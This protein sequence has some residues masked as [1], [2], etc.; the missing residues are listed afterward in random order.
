M[1]SKKT[2]KSFDSSGIRYR[3]SRRSRLRDEPSFAVQFDECRDTTTL[4]FHAASEERGICIGRVLLE[5]LAVQVEAREC[6]LL[7]TQ[8]VGRV[9]NIWVVD[10]NVRCKSAIK[11]KIE[12][13]GKSK[14]SS[15]PN[16][17]LQQR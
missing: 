8:Q 13:S 10:Y 12:T 16:K 5:T 7:R 6:P 4:C 3:E 17:E 11:G 15:I 9:K 14:T 2:Q 1:G